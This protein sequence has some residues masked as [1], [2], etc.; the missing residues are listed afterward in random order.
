MPKVEPD[1]CV[2]GRGADGP[3][4]GAICAA[5]G[6]VWGGAA[7]GCC[8]G[9][10]T[11]GA[12]VKVNC[13][14]IVCWSVESTFQ[15]TVY[16]PDSNS[17]NSICNFLSPSASVTLFLSTRLPVLSVTVTV[18][19]EASSS[20]LNQSSTLFGVCLSVELAAGCERKR[21]ACADAAGA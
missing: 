17:S 3:C 18:L 9:G 13:P 4:V 6:A 12:T 2:D 1:S 11:P 21:R 19:I 16:V 5:L 15:S 14:F 10:A 8:V 7:E 20:S